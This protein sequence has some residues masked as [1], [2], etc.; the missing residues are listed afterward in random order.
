[1]ASEANSVVPGV[2]ALQEGNAAAR[3]AAGNADDRHNAYFNLA[4]YCALQNDLAC[5]E[6]NLRQAIDWAPN[7]FKPHWALAKALQL[8]GRFDEAEKEAAIAAY[9]AG[10]AYSEVA[11]T[12]AELRSR[13][14]K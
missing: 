12:L 11:H 6:T 2:L 13:R 1:L 10:D 9:L 3:R 4:T 7:W 8:A 14:N 5:V